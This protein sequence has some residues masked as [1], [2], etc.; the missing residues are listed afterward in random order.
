M[1]EDVKKAAFAIINEHR[2]YG[3]KPFQHILAA[4]HGAAQH[5]P[6]DPPDEQALPASV[7]R[8]RLQGSGRRVPRVFDL[9]QGCPRDCVALLSSH[10][11]PV[12]CLPVARAHTVPV[13]VHE[14]ELE[15][16]L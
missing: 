5:R 13:P 4:R 15:L 12:R 16:G 14:T 10:F 2:E 7:Q 6:V 3:L 8:S 11:E 9:R 1:R